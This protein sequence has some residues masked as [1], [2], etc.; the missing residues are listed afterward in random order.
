MCYKIRKLQKYIV[1]A[2]R[3]SANFHICRRS[4]NITNFVSPQN[5]RICDLRNLFAERPPLIFRIRFIYIVLQRSKKSM[6]LA[7]RRRLIGRSVIFCLVY[8][9]NTFLCRACL[10]SFFIDH[11]S[12]RELRITSIPRD[13]AI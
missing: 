8:K 10:H 12:T 5:L 1:S 4:A 3:K 2:N 6:E 7:M 13:A 11:Q 9:R